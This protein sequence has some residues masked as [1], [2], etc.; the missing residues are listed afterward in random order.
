MGVV[1]SAI[2]VEPVLSGRDSPPVCLWK[3]NPHRLVSWWDVEQFS[4]KSLHEVVCFLEHM[5]CF[6]QHAKPKGDEVIAALM[7]Q[8]AVLSIEGHK[9][10]ESTLRHVEAT[11]K[12]SG[13]PTSAEAVAELRA[14]FN[15]RAEG[16]GQAFVSTDVV[17]RIDEI[18]RTIRRE[19]KTVVFLYIGSERA[20]QFTAPAEDW[21]SS[22]LTRWPE[23]RVDIE[24]A[25]KCLALNRFAA[26]LFHVLL[27]AEFGVIQ[28]CKLLEKCGDRPGWGCVGGLR[29]IVET[30]Y[31]KRSSLEQEHSKLLESI[32]P[33]IAAL[34]ADRHRLTHVGN[35][36]DW[37]V[38]EIGP[39]TAKDAI[40]ATRKFMGR[41]AI[42]LPTVSG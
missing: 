16:R 1:M 27:V 40:A 3:E 22:V 5:R 9:T 14:D 39:N 28:V 20:R 32:M 24:E 11:L 30:P 35:K 42:D 36:S 25:S 10:T 6:W 12:K 23:M 21:S 13:L 34:R 18:Q 41:L 7:G 26:A 19:M 15:L 8:L 31:E 4:G 33:E 29:R 37:L 2:D 17:A 38:R